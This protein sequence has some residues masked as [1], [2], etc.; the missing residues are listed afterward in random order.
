MGTSQAMDA[1]ASLVPPPPR[2]ASALARVLSLEP[3]MPIGVS[4]H[5][6]VLLFGLVAFAPTRLGDLSSHPDP[7]TTYAAAIQRITSVQRAE[8]SVVASGGGS[9]LLSHGRATPRVVVLFHGLT[10]SP[11]QFLPFA[12]QLYTEGANVYIPRLPHHAERAGN[13]AAMK[14]L[15]AQELRDVGDASTDIARGL[16]D[17]VIVAGLSAGGTI[18][19]WI[20]Q[21][22]SEVRRVVLIAPALEV[23]HIP[24]MLHGAVLRIALRVPNV[25]RASPHDST[26]PDREPGWATHA[27]AQTLKL[28]VAVRNAAGDRAPQAREMLFLLNAHD[29]TVAASASLDLAREWRRH[30]DGVVRVFELPDS[31]ELPHDVVDPR[32]PG[33][34]PRAVFPVLDALVIGK[35]PLPWVAEVR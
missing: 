5:A 27:V 35:T 18:A 14:R 13:V 25:T 30:G 16:G 4:W 32:H 23:T 9:I 22:R 3:T 2:D 34:N 7:V 31:L 26:E 12:Q 19:A 24:S 15:T 33:S 28:G 20:G 6:V 17:T 8:D 10:D 1:R 11:T 21:Y 29:H